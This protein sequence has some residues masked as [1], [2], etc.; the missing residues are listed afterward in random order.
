MGDS[1]GTKKTTDGTRV[2]TD[3]I[4]PKMAVRRA[5]SMPRNFLFSPSFVPFVPTPNVKI[6]E[7]CLFL[8]FFVQRLIKLRSVIR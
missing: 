3:R 2:S 1:T 8:L 5:R 7:R 4:Y 6:F